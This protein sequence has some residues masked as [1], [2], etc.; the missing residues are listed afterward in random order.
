MAEQRINVK[1]AE[2]MY[3]FT[4]KSQEQESLIRFAAERVN[5]SFDE[6]SVKYPG[7]SALDKLSVVA[8]NEC[9][10]SLV[11]SKRAAVVE[12]EEESLLGDLRAYLDDIGNSR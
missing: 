12:E 10:Q 1:I 7:M 3:S 2:K 6:F 11:Q 4:V 5:K 9:R 8:L